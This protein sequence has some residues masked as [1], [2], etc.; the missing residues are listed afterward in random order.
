MRDETITT[1]FTAD[2]RDFLQRRGYTHILSLGIDPKEVD[3]ASEP[4]TEK[5]NYWLK[6]VKND[7][8]RLENP[9][10]KSRLQINDP[11]VKAMVAG[12]ENVQF[13]VKVPLV[14]YNDYLAKR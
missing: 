2:L 7:D 14:D 8:T 12:E 3:D 6:P 9:P 13:M 10:G 4:E 5:E 1:E 11:E